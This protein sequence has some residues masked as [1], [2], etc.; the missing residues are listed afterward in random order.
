MDTV[1]MIT[2]KV[3]TTYEIATLAL[4]SFLAVQFLSC[5]VYFR[6]D[7][8]GY[9]VVDVVKKVFVVK[10]KSENPC[11]R[12]CNEPNKETSKMSYFMVPM[13]CF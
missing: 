4:F 13:L 6:C 9:G 7:A 2:M 11:E 12:D 1:V 3:G 5:I 10:A 8:P